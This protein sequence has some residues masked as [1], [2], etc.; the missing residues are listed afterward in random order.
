MAKLQK[1]KIL[2]LVGATATG[3]SSLSLVLAETLAAEIV[4]SDSRLIYKMMDIGTAK[5]TIEERLKI[6]HHMID[7]VEANQK[8]SLINFIEKATPLILDI[9]TRGKL[10][11]I[12]GGTGFYLKGLVGDLEINEFETD[13][14]FRETL[15]KKSTEELYQELKSIDLKGKWKMH[16]ND[17]YRIIRALEIESSPKKET[18]QYLANQALKDNFELVWIGL[19]YESRE[20]LRQNI[21][22]RTHQMVDNGLIE[23][24]E[25]L[26]NEYGELELFNKTIGYKESIEYLKGNIKSKTDLSELISIATRQY[27]KRQDT[28]FRANS[29][30]QWLNAESKKEEQ[31][32]LINKSFEL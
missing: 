32:Y 4:S 1:P 12:V 7:L 28:W 27:A 29:K 26:L 6:P 19:Q 16:P 21:T 17:R 31:L 25:A 8:F 20:K 15:Q 3:K 11:I 10:P 22:E 18:N 14:S 24:T 5:P 2:I 23:E 13:L 30:I 9:S